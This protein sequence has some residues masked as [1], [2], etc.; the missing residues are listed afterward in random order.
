MAQLTAGRTLVLRFQLR[1]GDLSP[2]YALAIV[3]GGLGRAHL[4]MM[5]EKHPA[6]GL[7]AS[8]GIS[9]GTASPPR[10]LMSSGPT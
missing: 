10:R 2:C 3:G 1:C 5:S 7:R 9:L 4:W 8:A 6:I